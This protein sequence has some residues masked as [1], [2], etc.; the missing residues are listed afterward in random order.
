MARMAGAPEIVNLDR[1]LNELLI[2]ASLQRGAKHGYQIALEIEERSGGYFGFK[3]GTLYPIL[4]H[5]EKEGLID[6]DWDDGG[7]RRRKK[8]YVLT[9]E[10]RARLRAQLDGWGELHRRLSDFVVASAP[11]RPGAASGG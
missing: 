8:E 5:L 7:S 4:H 1:S 10:G 9:D 11:L 2:L 6:G 3:H